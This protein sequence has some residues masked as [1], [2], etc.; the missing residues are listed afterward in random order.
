[1]THY[2][3]TLLLPTTIPQ[4]AVLRQLLL[5]FETIFLYSPTESIPQH[6]SSEIHSLCRQY[7]PVPFGDGLQTFQRLI[8]DMT[9]N[10]AEYYGGGLSA[11]S[12]RL[13]AV[14]EESVWQLIHRLSPPTGEKLHSETLLQARL[15]LQLAEIQDRENQELEQ[16]L[17]TLDHRQE[18]LLKELAHDDAPQ[19]VECDPLIASYQARANDHLEQRLRAWGHLFLADADREKHWLISTTPAV[20][21]IL[22]EYATTTIQP[23][24]N[25]L[26]SLPIPG[27][28][29]IMELTP[30]EY[31]T[32]RRVFRQQASTSLASL[33]I[34]IKEATI[35]GTFDQGKSLLE[36]I[37]AAYQ[38]MSIC[39]DSNQATLD[40]YLLPISL[41]NL[42]AKITKQPAPGQE[43]SP[44]A[45]VVVVQAS[46]IIQP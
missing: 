20:M 30:Q 18:A 5:Y 32:A 29:A 46:S 33:A 21:A 41:A 10:R 6:L 12:T 17:N 31:L 34:G 22:N 19:P 4:E 35:S 11:I 27:A 44:Y 9:A 23:S 24:P 25:R 3:S 42:F 1:M 15:L 40:L 26:L 39:Q 37:A 45:L 28:K 7:A 43:T 38:P 2:F 8:H 16:E 13:R 14:D 36:A